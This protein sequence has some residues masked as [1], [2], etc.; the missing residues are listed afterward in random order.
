VKDGGLNIGWVEDGR[1]MGMLARLGECAPDTWTMFP[2]GS[3]LELCTWAPGR[4]EEPLAGLVRFRG[5]T[6]GRLETCVWRLDQAFPAVAAD[7]LREAL[8]L[9]EAAGGGLRLPL[10]NPEE[11]E[12]VLAAF[13][14][15][16]GILVDADNPLTRHGRELRFAT[17][18]VSSMHYVAA[19][20]FKMRYAS[21]W[22]MEPDDEDDEED[23]DPDGD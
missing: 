22:T 7:T 4:E 6:R 14:K 20:A 21:T 18:D 2:E 12:A 5:T 15:E 16:W 23:E 8:A 13:M 11:A 1:P 3:T 9:S 17:A 10:R 19:R